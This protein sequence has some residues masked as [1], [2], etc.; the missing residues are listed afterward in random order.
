MESEK[1]F[2][3]IEVIDSRTGQVCKVACM[4]CI[5]GHRTTSCGIP[6]CRNKVFWTV[7]RPGRPSNSCTCRFG[8]TG[9]CQCVVAKSACPHKPKKGEKRSTDCR[10]D[11][12]G[13]FCCVLELEQ[14]TILCAMQKPKVDFFVNLEALNDHQAAKQAPSY[15]TP[16]PSANTPQT[17][18]S[19]PTTP[20]PPHGGRAPMMSPGTQFNPVQPTPPIPRF[21][22]MGVGLPMGYGGAEA[23]DVLIWDGQAPQAPRPYQPYYGF[24]QQSSTE[25]TNGVDS[26]ALEKAPQ[27]YMSPIAPQYQSSDFRPVTQSFEQ[28]SLPSHEPSS[29]FDFDK[30][31]IDYHNYQ[32]PSAICQSCGLN[33]CS[34]RSCPPMMQNFESGSWAHGCSR[35][36]V[37][38]PAAAQPAPCCATTA[39]SGQ[40]A[41][42][43]IDDTLIQNGDSN[44]ADLTSREDPTLS[45][46]FR[47]QMLNSTASM[48]LSEFLM[49]DLEQPPQGCCCGGR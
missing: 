46:D 31:I 33:G 4:S 6:V 15:P 7:K 2:K 11:E 3:T 14:W 40:H 18:N 5:R 19:Q 48:D 34:C 24:Q 42:V 49:N 22:M 44:V 29:N 35:K 17:T 16:T 41:P 12:Q 39:A 38:L 23:Q 36:H 27:G 32:F 25:I 13:R 10:C 47:A 1:P 45:Q 26:G 37:H 20:A 30:M 8:S 21:G 9:R 28:M 43:L